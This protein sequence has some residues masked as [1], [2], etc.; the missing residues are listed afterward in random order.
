MA[1]IGGGCPSLLRPSL[2]SGMDQSSS[3]WEV[4]LLDVGWFLGTCSPVH[5]GMAGLWQ[6]GLPL[7]SGLLGLLIFSHGA[8]SGPPSS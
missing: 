5:A 7:A 6:D 3:T 8:S 1:D 2:W 4:D